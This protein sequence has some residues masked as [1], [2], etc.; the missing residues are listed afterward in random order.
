MTGTGYLFFHPC[1]SPE[2]LAD[3][4]LRLLR[5]SREEHFRVCIGKQNLCLVS[6][7]NLLKLLLVLKAKHDTYAPVSNR[8]LQIIY[9]RDTLVSSKFVEQESERFF[10]ALLERKFAQ[11]I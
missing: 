3:L 8:R 10:E 9:A 4:L 7:I 1:S 6:R 2:Q 5:T 11:E